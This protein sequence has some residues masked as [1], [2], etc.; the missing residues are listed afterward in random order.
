MLTL[1]LLNTDYSKIVRIKIYE[2]LLFNDDK[3]LQ[4]CFSRKKL[5]H[6]L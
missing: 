5:T 3:L 1:L 2:N 4:E 6:S